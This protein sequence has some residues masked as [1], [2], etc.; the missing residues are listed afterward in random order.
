M[1]LLHLH[2]FYLHKKKLSKSKYVKFM[3]GLLTWRIDLMC[4]HVFICH[5]GSPWNFYLLQLSL[6]S[7]L[8]WIQSSVPWTAVLHCSNIQGRV[9]KWEREIRRAA[10]HILSKYLC[11][12]YVD[13]AYHNIYKPFVH[14]ISVLRYYWSMWW[15]Q[16]G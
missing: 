2:A 12:K 14:D 11:V 9:G 10:R 1:F 7:S 4:V 5:W 8:M 15:A 13:V 3:E 16:A 6:H